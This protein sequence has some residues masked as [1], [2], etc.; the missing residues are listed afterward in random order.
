MA[1]QRRNAETQRRGGKNRG[2]VSRKERQE[3]S[4]GTRAGTGKVD[5]VRISGG[6][7]GRAGGDVQIQLRPFLPGGAIGFL[8]AGIPDVT[9]SLVDGGSL[10]KTRKHVLGCASE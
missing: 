9:Y 7:R 10:S 3:R 2:Q 5:S 8:I 4:E 6:D 1:N